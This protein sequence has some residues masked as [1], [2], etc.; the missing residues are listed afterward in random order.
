MSGTDRQTRRA[1]LKGEAL[2]RVEDGKRII[3]VY[4]GQLT[5]DGELITLTRA[6]MP[7]GTVSFR[8]A[9]VRAIEWKDARRMW[10]G[11]VRFTVPDASDRPQ[12]GTYWTKT[13]SDERRRY[14][15]TFTTGQAAPIRALCDDIESR[16][17][18]G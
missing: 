14:T 6:T 5:F 2:E 11:E 13:G 1:A 17:R 7:R 18:R 10:N 9:D 3:D 12:D 4:G 15:L 8:A 16:M